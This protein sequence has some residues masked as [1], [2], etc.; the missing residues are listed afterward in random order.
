M[1]VKVFKLTGNPFLYVNLEYVAATVQGN[2]KDVSII[3]TYPNE[4]LQKLFSCASR[5]KNSLAHN[6]D[7]IEC[8]KKKVVGLSQ[9]HSK[10]VT[11][12]Q[13]FD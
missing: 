12:Y 5:Y 9:K 11:R 2:N 6:S 3:Y 7:T 4:Y 1:Y 13:F 10:K 8:Q